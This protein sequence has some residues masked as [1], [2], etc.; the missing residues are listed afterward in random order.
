MV[1]TKGP[2]WFV[3]IAD[4]GISRRRHQD[5]TTSLTLQRGTLGFAAPEALGV[6][7]EATYSF[8][9]DMW[10]LG[11]VAYRILTNTSAFLSLSDLFRYTSG[12]LEFPEDKLMSQNVSE[13][14]RGFIIKLMQPVPEARLSA[15]QAMLDPWFTTPLAT[16]EDSSNIPHS[17]AVE[18]H[19]ITDVSMPSKAWSTDDQTTVS[20]PVPIT[21]RQ[22]HQ[23]T[24]LTMVSKTRSPE[25]LTAIV[26]HRTASPFSKS[27]YQPPSVED[28]SDDNDQ[29]GPLPKLPSDSKW[30]LDLE[31]DIDNDTASETNATTSWDDS[32]S[33]F[34]EPVTREDST[35]PGR[36][37]IVPFG[38]DQSMHT[39]ESIKAVY[40]DEESEY[41]TGTDSDSDI[42]T[43]RNL[44]ENTKDGASIY[45]SDY[46]TKIRESVKKGTMVLC[47]GCNDHYEW[48]DGQIEYTDKNHMCHACLLQSLALSLISPKYMRAQGPGASS[49]RNILVDQRINDARAK[50]E[51]LMEHD[52]WT[53]PRGHPPKD[54]SLSITLGSLN[55]PPIW[56]EIVNCSSCLTETRLSGG[57]KERRPTSFCIL[58]SSEISGSTCNQCEQHSVVWPFVKRMQESIDA[59]ES[60]LS[61]VLR[62]ACR[63]ME[64]IRRGNWMNCQTLAQFKEEQSG[65]ET[66][67]KEPLLNSDLADTQKLPPHQRSPGI[68][69]P[70]NNPSFQQTQYAP[71]YNAGAQQQPHYAAPYP[72]QPPMISKQTSERPLSFMC[73]NCRCVLSLLP[74]WT[75]PLPRFCFACER[76]LLGQNQVPWNMRWGSTA[77]SPLPPTNANPYLSPGSIPLQQPN[78]PTIHASHPDARDDINSRRSRPRRKENIHDRIPSAKP[79]EMSLSEVRQQPTKRTRARKPKAGRERGSARDDHDTRVD[80]AM[81]YIIA[82]RKR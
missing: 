31:D 32:T 74:W 12:M 48:E 65:S 6:E 57:F 39:E 5:V 71:A 63:D 9:V 80:D 76:A 41:E 40:T 36:D 1:V 33:V 7:S 45:A 79:D 13:L 81:A 43:S 47:H 46:L 22:Y 8:W 11:A 77:T 64:M 69:P 34:S 75:G 51:K 60:W 18:E 23:V 78:Y 15:V 29:S 38:Q 19:D 54:G 68:P 14:G 62:F 49:F 73:E 37:D 17:T 72:N 42:T 30:V 61:S 82:A 58:C 70:Y 56:K 2:N 28:C 55:S 4:F 50:Y 52:N 67:H 26:A 20:T 66:E 44:A 21:T 27:N 3:K 16:S 25:N 24:D 10:S 53:C 59:P 35:L